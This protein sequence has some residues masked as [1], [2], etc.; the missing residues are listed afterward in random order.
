MRRVEFAKDHFGRRII[1]R[2]SRRGVGWFESFS[3]RQEVMR[4]KGGRKSW[5]SSHFES[6]WIE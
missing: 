5:D 1:G 2:R 3:E 6:T 4:R